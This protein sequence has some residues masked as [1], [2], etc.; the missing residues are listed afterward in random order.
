MGLFCVYGSRRRG[1]SFRAHC[2]LVRL[3]SVEEKSR[4]ADRSLRQG[5][6]ARRL[7]REIKAARGTR[8]RTGRPK[9]TPALRLVEEL[10]RVMEAEALAEVR[11]AA[12]GEASAAHL[13]ALHRELVRIN[14]D[15]RELMGEVARELSSRR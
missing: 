6:S 4:W 10:G 9:K 3:G 2:A 15:C 5:W 7:E 1:L 8:G 11:D 12:L 13:S 14:E